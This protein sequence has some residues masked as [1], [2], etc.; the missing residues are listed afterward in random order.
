MTDYAIPGQVIDAWSSWPDGDAKAI[1]IKTPTMEVFRFHLDAG[2][3]V[4]AHEF[5]GEMMILCV[6]GGVTVI[7]GGSEHTLVAGQLLYLEAKE[8]LELLAAGESSLL[9]TVVKQPRSDVN[10]LIGA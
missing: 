1:I 5:Q 2:R 10:P 8:R 4:P 7:S 3:R 9:I 6:G